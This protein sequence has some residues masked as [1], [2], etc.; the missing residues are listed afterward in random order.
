MYRVVGSETSEPL[1][2]AL[3]V[4]ERYLG[5]GRVSRRG[6]ST[7]AAGVDSRSDRRVAH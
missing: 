6:R 4:D 7:G 5:L 1:G 3:R 2:A